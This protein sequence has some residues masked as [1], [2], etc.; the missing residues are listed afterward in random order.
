MDEDGHPLE[1]LQVFVEVSTQPDL[2]SLEADERT[3]VGVSDREGRLE[4]QIQM[5]LISS[6]PGGSHS[7]DMLLDAHKGIASH[8]VVEVWDPASNRGWRKQ[9]T[10]VD[11]S[12]GLDLG[13]VTVPSVADVNVRAVDGKGTPVRGAIVVAP[14]CT[15]FGFSGALIR[16]TPT[17]QDGSTVISGV[18]VGTPDLCVV[19]VGHLPGRAVI[20][21][22]RAQPALVE[23]ATATSLEVSVHAPAGIDLDD[24]EVELIAPQGVSLFSVVGERVGLAM[25]SSPPSFRYDWR[26]FAFRLDSEGRLR[27]SDLAPDELIQVRLIQ[28]DQPVV[29]DT[30]NL[31]P[32]G[33]Q[34]GKAVALRLQ[35]GERRTLE[36]P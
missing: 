14:A 3:F 23:L 18:P 7:T 19:A 32:P 10:D 22:D 13:R 21:E 31:R 30:R 36:L 26:Q 28:R 20:S 27:L 34:V 9:D 8:L 11:L 24:L 35:P 4:V 16:S 29:G 6:G 15:K 12:A 5:R 33:K 25:W 1:G 2:Y 17:G